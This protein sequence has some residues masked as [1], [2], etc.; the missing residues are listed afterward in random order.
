M[1]GHDL[2]LAWMSD[3]RQ[4]TLDHFRDA[5][6]WVFIDR[7]PRWWRQSLQGLQ[8]LG[9]VEVFE[10]R[11]EIAA[12]AVT[13]LEDGGGYALLCGARPP[14]LL[15][16]LRASPRGVELVQSIP[17]RDGPS[18]QLIGYD[19]E[20]QL[21]AVCEDLGVNFERT[22]A[23]RMLELAPTLNDVLIARRI[24]D[25]MP[26]GALLSELKKDLS[27][28]E[29]DD[30]RGATPGAYCH[31]LF[32]QRRYFYRHGEPPNPL[33]ESG[34]QEVRYAELRRLY[35]AEHGSFAQPR[36]LDWDENTRQLL[37]E[38][39]QRLPMIYEKATV[40]RSGLLPSWSASR[41]RWTYHNVSESF[42]RIL[43][44]KLAA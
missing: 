7:D 29:E 13:T 18:L 40:L 43:A 27:F 8:A 35:A 28:S 22:V 23:D 17:Q 33:F 41:Q 20:D 38:R 15:S 21:A 44:E 19:S 1:T 16:A 30:S 5:W 26:G 10:N 4:G 39:R 36:Q 34:L 14:S 37:V 32:R 9:H 31:E 12:P 6:T 42:Q 11:W 3:R 24:K 2:V 25:G